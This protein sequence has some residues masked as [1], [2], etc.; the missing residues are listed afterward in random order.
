MK[1]SRPIN[2]DKTI[3]LTSTVRPPSAIT[4]IKLE[5]SFNPKGEF[6]PDVGLRE[7]IANS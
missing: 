4:A 6:L 7:K 1:E 3:K 2:S 5:I